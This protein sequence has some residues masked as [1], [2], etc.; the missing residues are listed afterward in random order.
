MRVFQRTDAIIWL[1]TWTNM[2]CMYNW[3]YVQLEANLDSWGFCMQWNGRCMFGS[4]CNNCPIEAWDPFQYWFF[5]HNSNLME[6][7]YCCTS[8]TAHE[9]ITNIYTCCSN[10][11]VVIFAKVCSSGTHLILSQHYF[12]W[13]LGATQVPSHYLNQWWPSSL[14]HMCHQASMSYS[15]I[16]C[17][18]GLLICLASTNIGSVFF[19]SIIFE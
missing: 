11:A 18:T 3:L 7:L 13:W 14:M 10:T 2:V 9:I 12:R 5:L 15:Y 8:I 17:V 4:L 1:L 19:T 6:N 16:C